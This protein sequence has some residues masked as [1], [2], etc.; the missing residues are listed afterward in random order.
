RSEAMPE[1]GKEKR[2]VRT[3]C[4]YTDDGINWSKPQQIYE[5]H[6]W[7]WGV[8][9]ADGI[10]YG[11]AYGGDGK[12]ADAATHL[13]L[14]RSNDALDWEKVSQV[15]PDGSEATF[16]MAEDGTMRVAIRDKKET[17]LSI[18]TAKPP[19][20]DWQ[21]TDVDKIIPAP[22]LIQVGGQEYIIGRHHLP[23]PNN[24]GSYID[25]RTSVWR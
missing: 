7:V 13:H 6:Y 9:Y 1:V 23:D 14:V 24:P 15:S 19:F 18:A 20:E 16:R 2:Y 11:L 10:F 22:K 17:R 25:R 4:S 8:G 3:Y 21:L 5:D 12:L